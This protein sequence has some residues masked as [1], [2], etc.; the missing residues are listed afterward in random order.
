MI[1]FGRKL[2]RSIDLRHRLI[3]SSP[4]NDLSAKNREAKNQQVIYKKLYSTKRPQ[5]IE[6]N[7]Q[8][9]E[10]LNAY[11]A[12]WNG[13]E[14]TK[15]NNK[16]LEEK[17]E[18]SS[19]ASC[20]HQTAN[21]LPKSS[22]QISLIIPSNKKEIKKGSHPECSSLDKVNINPCG[23]QMLSDSIHQQVFKNSSKRNHVS[24]ETLAR[25]KQHLSS[26]N[27]W[28]RSAPPLPNVN[29][30]LP[31]L[32]GEGL[33][34]HFQ[35]I[36]EKQCRIYREYIETFIAHDVPEMP[37]H[38]NFS[39]GWTCYNE[40]GQMTQV[41][42]LD[43]DAY[44]FDVEVCVKEGH[45]PTIATAVSTNHWYSWCSPQL[46]EDRVKDQQTNTL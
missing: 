20:A 43:E 29:L 27:L 30:T 22:Q 3:F 33:L 16:Q 40:A 1:V 23:I 6:T 18:S 13:L 28:G 12:S 10:A 34:E 36:A 32:D 9:I 4:Q 44:V 45:L 39:P 7:S 21:V 15:P 5:N 38:W 24:E 46:F 26:H 8:S 25:V 31:P 2:G 11:F 14:Q 37:T 35:N 41:D 19:K 42:Y 17:T